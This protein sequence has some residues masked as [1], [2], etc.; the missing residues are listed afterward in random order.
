VDFKV[1]IWLLL[2]DKQPS[3]KDFP[4]NFQSPLAAKLLIGSKNLGGAKPG[5]TSSITMPSMV[6]IVGRAPAVDEKVRHLQKS[7]KSR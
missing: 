6:G 7:Q 5:R 2:G 1:L 3:Y 4:S